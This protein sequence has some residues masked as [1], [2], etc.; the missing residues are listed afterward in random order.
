VVPAPSPLPLWLELLHAHSPS[1]NAS[2][3]KANISGALLLDMSSLA[4][5]T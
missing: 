2:V 5:V 4:P 3:A 1:G